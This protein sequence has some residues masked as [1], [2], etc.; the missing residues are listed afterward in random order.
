MHCQQKGDD[1]DAALLKPDIDDYDFDQYF[2]WDFTTGE[3]KIKDTASPQERHRA[4]RT[5]MLYRLNEGHPRFR[6]MAMH[7]RSKDLDS[8]INDFPYRHYIHI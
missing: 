7:R 3:M 1:F 5:I 4:D 8:P 6:K 2:R